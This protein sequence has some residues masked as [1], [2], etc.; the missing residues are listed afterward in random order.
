MSEKGRPGG[1]VFERT[2]PDKTEPNAT[3][4]A[5]SVLKSIA[6][7]LP[8]DELISVC[9]GLSEEVEGGQRKDIEEL[10]D[11]DLI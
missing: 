1:W 3:M 7:T 4:S 9:N 11:D 10:L 5:F 8:E 6:F 2:R